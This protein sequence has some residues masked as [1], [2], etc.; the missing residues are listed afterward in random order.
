MK[1]YILCY[2]LQSIDRS[3]SI[4][5]ATFSTNVEGI[6]DVSSVAHHT[7][8][9]QLPV[10]IK[11]HAAVQKGMD[12]ADDRNLLEDYLR[13]RAL[14]DYSAS[15]NNRTPSNYPYP[16]KISPPGASF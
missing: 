11:E 1:A 7:G 13:H 6:T 2:E 9:A 3:S 8:T 16:F 14:L 5:P 15:F 10:V 4:T 12:D